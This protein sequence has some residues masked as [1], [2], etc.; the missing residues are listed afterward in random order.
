VSRLVPA[1]GVADF[2]PGFVSGGDFADFVLTMSVTHT[3]STGTGTGSFVSTDADGDTITG[4]I[5]GTW[6]IDGGYIAFVGT[7]SGVMINNV[8]ED[9]T[10]D[11]SNTGSWSTDFAGYTPPFD[12]AIVKLTEQTSNFF[13]ANFVNAATGLSAQITTETVPLPSAALAGFATLAGLGAARTARRR[14]A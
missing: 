7:L 8:S 4:N 11:G 5:S 2:Q 12:G 6:S 1:N 9:G 10:F 13:Q 3:G 14:T